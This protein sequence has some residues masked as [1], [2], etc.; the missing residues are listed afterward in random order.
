MNQKIIKNL[1]LNFVNKILILFQL[2]LVMFLFYFDSNKV[3]L[4]IDFLF[5]LDKVEVKKS[6]IKVVKV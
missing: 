3:I 2:K 6:V 4:E 5:F 1:W